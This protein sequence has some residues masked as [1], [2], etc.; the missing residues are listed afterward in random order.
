MANAIAF[1]FTAINQN[2]SASGGN[3]TAS[4]TNNDVLS[5]AAIASAE[6]NTAN[7]FALASDVAIQ[8]ADAT[9][10]GIASVLLTNLVVAT[11]T[12]TTAFIGAINVD[13]SATAHGAT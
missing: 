1:A 9:G 6:G 13:A 12:T 7:A 8:S 11:G 5:V 2:I 3:A 4:I 10:T